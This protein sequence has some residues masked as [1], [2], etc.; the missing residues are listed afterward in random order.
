MGWLEKLERVG[1]MWTVVVGW[2]CCGLLEMLEKLEG[3]WTV[4]LLEKLERL[5][6]VVRWW[7]VGEVGMGCEC[8]R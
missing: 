4:G 3:L 1:R 2:R 6:F 8:V 5:W 7:F